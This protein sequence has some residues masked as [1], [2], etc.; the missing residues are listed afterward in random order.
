[1]TQGH[2]G[3]RVRLHNRPGD[4]TGRFPLIVETL[5][6]EPLEVRK[7]M[8]VSGYLWPALEREQSLPRILTKRGHLA[9]SALDRVTL[10]H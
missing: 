1:M 4:L 9:A 6:R 10:P 2:G 5:A 8:L 3:E 7:A